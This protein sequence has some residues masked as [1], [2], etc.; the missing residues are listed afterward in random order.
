MVF[1]TDDG[2]ILRASV[3]EWTNAISGKEIEAEILDANGVATGETIEDYSCGLNDG[4]DNERIRLLAALEQKVLEQYDMIPTHN[5]SSASLLGY[6]VQYGN[7]EYVY[8]VG[9]GGIQYMTYNYTD[10][11]WDAYVASQG[12]ILNYK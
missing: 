4:K 1:T 6:Q 12:G 3:L 2:V 10:E 8:G 9:R 5:D 11:E 7:E